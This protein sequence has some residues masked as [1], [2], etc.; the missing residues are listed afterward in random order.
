MFCLCRQSGKR[1]SNPRPP[2]WQ[3]GALPLSYFRVFFVS[4]TD[5]QIRISSDSREVNNI[6]EK[7][8]KNMKISSISENAQKNVNDKKISVRLLS[9][10]RLGNGLF[11]DHF[12]FTCCQIY[13][14]KEVCP[15]P[16]RTSSQL[17]WCVLDKVFFEINFPTIL[18]P[19]NIHNLIHLC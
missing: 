10:Y 12:V 13:P 7:S 5:D 8:L 15:N 1:G 11:L 4:S 2:P 19:L 3:G 16:C 18:H 17:W 9:S 14:S 6:S